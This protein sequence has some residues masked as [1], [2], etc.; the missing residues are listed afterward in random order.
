M[1]A[2]APPPPHQRLEV[3]AREI[4]LPVY[5]RIAGILFIGGSL[6]AIPTSLTLEPMPPLGFYLLVVAGLI[7]GLVCL[8][9]PWESLSWRWLHA[10]PVLATLEIALAAWVADVVFSLYFI[11]VAVFIAAAFRDR[12][13]VLAHMGLVVIALFFPVIYEVEARRAV[14]QQAMLMLPG[15]VL[16]AGMIAYLRE[17]L[18]ERQLVY[19]RFA[20]EALAISRRL[21]TTAAESPGGGTADPPAGVLAEG[22]GRLAERTG[23]PALAHRAPRLQAAS[24]AG[25]LA[26]AAASVALAL[27]LADESVP[28]IAPVNLEGRAA[29]PPGLTPNGS[30]TMAARAR[31]ADSGRPGVGGQE[32][33]GVGEGNG[34]LV[35]AGGRDGAGAAGSIPVASPSHA[36]TPGATAPSTSGSGLDPGDALA[37][38]EPLPPAATKPVEQATPQPSANPLVGDDA[39]LEQLLSSPKA[40]LGS[41]MEPLVS[42]PAP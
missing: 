30:A 10:L 24:L 15:L 21:R 19:R 5:G 26:V 14:L 42:P 8:A 9:L 33:G 29:M 20:Q 11:F 2:P 31:P 40:L 27:T 41:N 17:R 36:P 39:L 32:S 3:G 37:R 1:Q 7:S 4:E 28:R 23:L 22:L 25:G 35:A 12:P 16:A 6:T 34:A 13:H 38:G 18:E